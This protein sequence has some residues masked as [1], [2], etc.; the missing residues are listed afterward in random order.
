MKK[1][2]MQ[3]GTVLLLLLIAFSINPKE[4]YY[5]FKVEKE[6]GIIRGILEEGIGV[7]KYKVKNME[8][9]GGNSFYV[10][11]NNDILLIQSKK[12]G[13]GSSYEI[14]EYKITIEKYE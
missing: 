6:I 4:L 9:L 3:I 5:S 13:S 1:Y 11:T 12:Q 7:E 10:E 8:H 14:Y 2:F